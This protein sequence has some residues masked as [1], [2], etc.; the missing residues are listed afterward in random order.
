LALTQPLALEQDQQACLSLIEATPHTGRYHQ[1]RRHL[2]YHG[3]PIVGDFRYAGI[4]ES[5]R[6]GAL[7]GTGT[8]MLLQSKS[9]S[10]T[11]PITSE[12]IMIVAPLD[13]F[14][15]IHFPGFADT[16]EA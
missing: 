8:R 6:L 5:H 2:L 15:L 3:L 1:I 12:Q 16:A 9:F 11:H 13:P 4:E 10:F 7:L 14:F